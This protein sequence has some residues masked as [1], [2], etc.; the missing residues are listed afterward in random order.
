MNN[1]GALYVAHQDAAT[2]A[3]AITQALVARGLRPVERAPGSGGA[4]IMVP[5]KQ[6]RLFFVAPAT[7]G[8]VAVWEDPRYFGDRELARALA[9]ALGTRAIWLEVSGNAVGWCYGIYDGD[10]I[11]DECYEPLDTTFYGEYGTIYFAF[12]LD[13][14]PEE[15]IEQHRLPYDDLHYEAI[16]EGGFPVEQG[17]VLHLAFER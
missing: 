16:A 4:R 6:L 7:H 10:A 8:W 14:S 1:S 9:H 2:V 13:L 3:A 5:D 17:Q 11:V 15:F 12:N